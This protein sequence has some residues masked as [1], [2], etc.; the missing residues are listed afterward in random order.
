MAF[1][2]ATPGT[3]VGV[4]PLARPPVPARVGLPLRAVDVRWITAFIDRAADDLD[5]AA[6]FWCEVG[7]SS[8]SP[9]RG[10]RGEFA[11]LLPA[12]GADAHLRVQRTRSGTAGSHLDLHVADVR[13]GIHECARLGASVVDDLDAYAVLA[14]P[15]TRPPGKPLRV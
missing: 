1:T 4:R 2:W 9:W 12:D 14:V 13:T 11:T 3:P 6:A 7:G 10:Q 15:L 5:A 8:L